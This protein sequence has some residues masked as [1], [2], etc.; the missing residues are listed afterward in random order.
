MAGTT[1]LR[2]GMIIMH[3]GEPCILIEKEFYSPGKGAAFNR[4]KLKSIKTRKI[5]SEVIKSGTKVDELD[6]I[7]K[8]VSFLYEDGINAYFMD[9]ETFEQYDILLS[10]IQGGKSFLYTEGKYIITLYEGKPI[11]LQIPAKITLTVVST[12]EGV[13]GDT[14]S[15]ATK[16]AELETGLVVQVPL[17]IK[18]GDKIVVNT[19]E[20][21][22][23][24]KA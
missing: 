19:E 3:N 1:E 10:E 16:E 4:C 6:V 7:S 8:T 17:F 13:K 21:T 5:T 11:Y 23:Y 14:V 15:N 9:P 20:Q 12:P 22:Y 2:R 24:S 18:N